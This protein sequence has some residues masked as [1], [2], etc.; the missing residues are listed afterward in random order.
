M[1][2]HPSDP[3]VGIVEGCLRCHHDGMAVS[4]GNT[5][6]Y[7]VKNRHRDTTN[8]DQ[9]RLACDVVGITSYLIGSYGGSQLSLSLQLVLTLLGWPQSRKDTHPCIGLVSVRHLNAPTTEKKTTQPL[10]FA[11]ESQSWQALRGNSTFCG[12]IL[13]TMA[14][15]QQSKKYSVG[16]KSSNGLQQWL[17]KNSKTLPKTLKFTN[18]LRFTALLAAIPLPWLRETTQTKTQLRRKVTNC[19]TSHLPL[20]SIPCNFG[21]TCS[22]CWVHL[23]RQRYN[24]KA[25]QPC[26]LALLPSKVRLQS[27]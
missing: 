8:I 11:C 23:G 17:Q 14:T 4:W 7:W 18:T 6:S 16:F 27:R 13:R 25:H 10:N 22:S 3:L 24:K 2:L 1:Q 9:S 5:Q 12:S 20:P 26:T 21:H 15:N 19:T